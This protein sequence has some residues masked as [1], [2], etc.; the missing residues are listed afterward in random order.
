[1]CPLR[2]FLLK[3]SGT[4]PACTTAPAYLNA[5]CAKLPASVGL[6]WKTSQARLAS[7]ID[8]VMDAIISVDAGQHIVFFNAAV[9]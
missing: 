4:H 5:F 3:K 6:S 1:M 8:S 7:I 9:Y 2:T